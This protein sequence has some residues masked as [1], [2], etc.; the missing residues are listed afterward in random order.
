MGA[1]DILYR[2]DPRG[3]D[4]V[5]RGSGRAKDLLF[6]LINQLWLNVVYEVHSF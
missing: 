2:D 5:S 6:C 4:L 3:V 1:A